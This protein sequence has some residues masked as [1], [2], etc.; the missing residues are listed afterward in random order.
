MHYVIVGGGIAGTTAAEELRK[1]V[2]EA[3]ITLLSEEHHPLYSRVL[4]PHYIKN[5]VPRERVFL[6]KESWYEEKNIEWL[7]GVVAM[8]LDARN[9][10]VTL[11]DGRELPYDKLLI[12]SGGDAQPPDEDRR[13]ISQLRTLD[14]ADHLLQL[15]RELPPGARAAVHGGGFMA[16]EYANIFQQFGIPSTVIHRGPHFWSSVLD[17]GSGTLITKKLIDGGFEVK[18]D[19]EIT[20][21]EGDDELEGVITNRGAVSCHVLGVGTGLHISLD[22]LAR[23]GVETKTGVCTNEFLE[24]TIPDVYAAGDIA[25]FFDVTAGHQRLAG[26]WMNAVSQAR[27]VAKTMA[28]ERTQFRLVS[29]Y[30]TNVLGLEIIFVGDTNRAFADQVFLRGS[31]AQ[32][33]VTQLF[34]RQGRL[35]GATLVNRNADRTAI[36]KLINEQ[37]DISK[38]VDRWFDLT[39]PITV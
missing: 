21:L 7:Q 13:G 39:V 28:G 5:K 30:A 11:S 32:R 6:K 3:E 37:T 35:V 4:L 25:E 24:T 8:S 16:C 27:A 9:R 19:T 36:T 26:N 29:S 10:F 38:Q 15:I 20:G 23:A 1:L 33:G 18:A 17:V 31:E 14:D 12:A 22:W 34:T 2:P